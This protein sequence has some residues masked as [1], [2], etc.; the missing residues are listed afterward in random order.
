MMKGTRV[1][2]LPPARASYDTDDEYE[3]KVAD[4]PIAYA[5]G[6]IVEAVPGADDVEIH[7]RGYA[8]TWFV[9]RSRLKSV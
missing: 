7:V 3:Q 5:E 6:W 4:C 8:D 1:E 9:H 2:I